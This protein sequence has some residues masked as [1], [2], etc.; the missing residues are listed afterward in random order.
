MRTAPSGL[1]YLPGRP[2]C[3]LSKSWKLIFCLE[4]F[5][6]FAHQA[7]DRRSVFRP[8]GLGDSDLGDFH[9]LVV[10]GQAL[11]YPLRTTGSIRLGSLFFT[12]P[13][14]AFTGQQAISSAG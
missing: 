9:H 11:R 7:R 12:L 6:V 1:A 10:D 14:R 5:D 4:R 3:S 13:T 2:A 8:D